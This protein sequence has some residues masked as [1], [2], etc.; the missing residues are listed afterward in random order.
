MIPYHGKGSPQ[1]SAQYGRLLRLSCGGIL[2]SWCSL[3]YITVVLCLRPCTHRDEARARLRTQVSS[4]V[5]HGLMLPYVHRQ[6]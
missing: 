2:S 4:A 6:L 3:R 5:A 1:V